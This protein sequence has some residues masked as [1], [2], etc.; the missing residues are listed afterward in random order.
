MKERRQNPNRTKPLSIMD[1]REIIT[2]QKLRAG[3]IDFRALIN[4]KRK[5]REQTYQ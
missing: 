3:R 2:S 4:S 1:A 5:E